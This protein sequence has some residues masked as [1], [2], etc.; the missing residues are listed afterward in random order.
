MASSA[1]FE[2]LMEPG[3]IGN[4]RLRNRIIKPASGSGLIEKDG[5]CGERIIGWYEAMAKGGAGLIIFETCATEHPRGNHRP[6]STARLSDDKY[7]PSYTKMVEAVHKHGCPFFIQLF[8]S[9]PWFAHNQGVEPGDRVAASPIPEEELPERVPTAPTREISTAEVEE[10]IDIFVKAAER[11]QKAGFDGMQVNASHYHLI[12]SF[13]S[14]FWNR[15]HDEYGCDTMENRAKFVTSIIREIKR[16]CGKDYPID[17]LMNAAEFGIKDGLTFEEAKQFAKMV[18]EAGADSL[19]LRC[20]GYGPFSGMLHTDRFFYPELPQEL[21]VKELDWSRKGK[22]I[23]IP[24]GPMFKEVVSIP[25]Y[26]AG[27]LDP[28][29]G[30]KILREGK[31]D[32]IGMT[33]RIIADPELPNKV[34]EGRLED[35]TPCSGCLYCWEIRGSNQP[36]KCRI[37]AALGKEREYEI[38]RAEKKKKVLVV[39]GGPAGLEA[40]RVAA[41]R[42]HEVILYEKEPKLGGLMRLAAM[43]KDFELE[44]ILEMIRYFRTQITKLGVTMRLGKEVNLRVIEEIKPDVLILA[45][46]GAPTI[47]AIPGINRRKVIDNAKLHLKIKSVMRFLGPKALEQLTKLWMPIGKRV[48][49]IGGAL[50]GCQLAEFLIKRGRKVTIVDTAEKLGE[51]LI[52][53]D[54]WRLF[55]WFER[56]GVVT[57]AG[58]RYEEIKEE[59]LVI[60]TREGERK[61]LEADTIITALL[62]QPNI[63]LIKS[64]EGKVPEIY[65]IGD[66]REAGYMPDAI[67]DGSR[68][69]RDI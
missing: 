64:L 44:D 32:F 51:G 27:R 50:Q 28:I 26:I 30:E 21:M 15:R 13:L 14:R 41:L 24:L 10:Q 17:V 25:V 40:A 11:A 29:L 58:V 69:A 6:P 66:C 55:R 36:L 5:T 45:T 37:N 54:P 65:Q 22:G 39:G 68:L 12:N 33:R 42:G 3:Y 2:K 31:L 1:R 52:S 43:V 4:V 59:G 61:T 35:I 67:A 60:T 18:E 46:G 63:E 8:H 23:N 48:I 49:I 56:K 9:G 16:R 53:D 57:I 20:A 7:I 19:Q 62:L 34:A 47:P 38:K